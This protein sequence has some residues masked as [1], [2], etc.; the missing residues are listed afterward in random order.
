[1]TKKT[2][3]TTVQFGTPVA[4]DCKR[5]LLF[6][7]MIALDV[8]GY[9]TIKRDSYAIGL[10]NNIADT[11]NIKKGVA[12]ELYAELSTY[13][14]NMQF[15]FTPDVPDEYRKI[16]EWWNK[17]SGGIDPVECYLFFSDSVPNYMTNFIREAIDSAHEIW[18][19]TEEKET[20]DGDGT[21]ADPK[22][23]DSE[24]KT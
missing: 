7:N 14:D 22:S 24:S 8:F 23:D 17:V 20:E 21:N 15:A 10:E 4:S 16:E 19:P 5:K 13:I 3:N 11:L 12:T 1:M 9:R 18:K 6:Y 2:A